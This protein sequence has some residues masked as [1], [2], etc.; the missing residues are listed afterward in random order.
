MVA[1]VALAEQVH[2]GPVEV[3]DG[4]VHPA[5]AVPSL[6]YLQEGVLHQFLR[7]GA[8]A[9]HEPQPPE[10]RL[11]LGLIKGLEGA[12]RRELVEGRVRDDDRFGHVGV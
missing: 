1:S 3:A 7:L 11:S 4:V 12:R 2:R 8:I 5:D 10:Q 6:P 9:G